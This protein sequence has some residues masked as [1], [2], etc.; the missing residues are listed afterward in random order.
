VFVI[1]EK[2]YRLRLHLRGALYV[3]PKINKPQVVSPLLEVN[4]KCFFNQVDYIGFILVSSGVRC[5]YIAARLLIGT[6]D[7]LGGVIANSFSYLAS[8][9]I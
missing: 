8:I 6:P 1:L 9:L 5:V 7:V 4:S 3:I 2:L